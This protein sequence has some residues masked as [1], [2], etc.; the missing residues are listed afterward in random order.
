[1]KPILRLLAL[2]TVIPT[3]FYATP[4]PLTNASDEQL[5]GLGVGTLRHAILSEAPAKTWETAFPVG[6]GRTGALAMG[7]AG[8]E[9]VILTRAGVFLPL[10][11]PLPPPS[12]GKHLKEIRELLGAGEYQRAADL[13]DAI[14]QREGYRGLHWPDPFVPVCSLQIAVREMGEVRDYL[15]SLDYPTGVIGTRWTDDAGEVIRRM[16]VSRADD[17]VVIAISGINRKIDC[18]FRFV[19]HDPTVSKPDDTPPADAFSAV[20]ITSEGP[21]ARFKS[22]FAKHWPG[23]LQG[24]EAVARVVAVG[25]EVRSDGDT[26]HVRGARDVLILVRVRGIDDLNHYKAHLLGESLKDFTGS[27][28]SLLARH[29]AQHRD[30]F[31]RVQLDLGGDP[32]DHRLPA[33]RLFSKSRIGAP[34][35]ALIEKQF[36]AARYLSISSNGDI[37]PPTL[38]GIWSGTW[39]PPWSSDFT[40]NGNLPVAIV[41]HLSTGMP[42]LLDGYFRY[43]ESRLKDYRVNAQRLFG[44]RGIV[45]PAHSSS[46][47]LTNHFGSR[48]C[49]TFWTAGAA[50][51][52]RTYHDYW[53]YTGDR[54]FLLKRAVPF[55]KEV[56]LF[57]EDF[58]RGMEGKDGYVLF[59]PSYSPEN[60]PINTRS[61]AAVN[62][63]MD[64]AAAR[65]LLRNLITV[66]EQEFVESDNVE[67]WRALLAKLPPY[68]INEDGAVAEWS[69][70]YLKDNYEHRHASHLYELFDGLPDHIRDNQRLLQAFRVALEKRTVWRRRIGGGEMAFGQ[71][72]MGA[73]AASLRIPEIA[74]ENLDML[75]NWFWFPDSMMTAHNPQEIF[76]TD[77]AGGIPHLITRMLVDSQPGW[78]ELLP[79]LPAS[80]PSGRITGLRCRGQIELRELVWAPKQVRV[81]LRSPLYQ[82]VEVRLPGKPRGQKVQLQPGADSTIT[83]NF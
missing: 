33:K 71:A 76:N 41:G 50:W 82:S 26:V 12:Q 47:G 52:A 65:E 46:H 77:I 45:V 43:H 44:A 32:A 66:C 73:V 30:L 83:L 62:A 14:G 40:H 35:P 18:S 58:L 69:V 22:E 57:Y 11:K 39:N 4:A 38:Q 10:T 28:G 21:E 1:M 25:A 64:V 68:R 67:R 6:N 27:F 31:N 20:R 49:H 13:V 36:D 72:Q 78:I 29:A 70:P 59:S 23:S 48:W 42:E 53:L 34:L 61:Q 60:D 51:V 2:L 63:T 54:D 17:A 55:M 7:R 74:F 81:T 79:A 37:V 75:S 56:A 15:R 16:F 80:W 3:A 5:R 24:A 19:H 9:T 8:R